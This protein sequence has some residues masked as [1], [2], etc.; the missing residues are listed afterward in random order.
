M[1]PANPPAGTQPSDSPT[2]S[3][4]NF[5]LSSLSS[6]ATWPPPPSHHYLSYFA[7]V[8]IEKESWRYSASRFHISHHC[9]PLSSL[10]LLRV[11]GAICSLNAISFSSLRDLIPGIIFSLAVI[12]LS[13]CSLLILYFFSLKNASFYT[14][15]TSACCTTLKTEALTICMSSFSFS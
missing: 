12:L 7:K 8:I 1:W 10:L 6:K 5:M 13:L 3:K 11:D 15:T 4:K 9:S 2:F 14:V